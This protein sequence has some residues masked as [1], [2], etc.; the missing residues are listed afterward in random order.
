MGR[1][2]IGR[3]RI[4]R[5]RTAVRH[6][7]G[8]LRKSPLRRIE[9]QQRSELL[10]GDRQHDAEH[11]RAARRRGLR[12]NRPRQMVGARLERPLVGALRRC[13]V[14]LHHPSGRDAAR[15]GHLGRGR[16]GR[17]AH[18]GRRPADRHAK[19]Q[20]HRRNRT[21]GVR[22]LRETD[23]GQA[24]DLRRHGIL[25]SHGRQ[26][27]AHPSDR[28]GRRGAGFPDRRGGRL[29]ALSE[30]LDE[31]LLAEEDRAGGRVDQPLVGRTHGSRAADLCRQRRLGGE[32]LRM[33]HRRRRLRLA[34][35]L[36]R[37]LRRR[38]RGA[39]GLLGRRLPQ[40]RQPGRRRQVLQHLPF[41]LR[42]DERRLGA[43][44]EDPREHQGG[45]QHAGFVPR[46]H[47]PLGE[48]AVFPRTR[49]LAPQRR[50][51]HERRPLGLR[52][53]E[54]RETHAQCGSARHLG[55]RPLRQD[56]TRGR[57][58]RVLH[59]ALGGRTDRPGRHGTRSRTAHSRAPTPK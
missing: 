38:Q 36:Q 29:L 41:R 45:R 17:I 14:P 43:L 58:L 16:R 12:R 57:H 53:G 4:H 48:G 21:R 47:E 10:C 9:R 52:N 26:Q 35:P 1:I 49:V 42:I 31:G 44:V 25:L 6:R 37:D 54:R 11:H 22:R 7:R 40:Q 23:S 28:R 50:D 2:Q 51:R 59:A 19:G 27:R 13:A 20:A 15:S 3:Q 46:L 34:L 8:Q 55:R 56:R 39:L 24:E 18:A 32:G 33:G 30:V 5:I